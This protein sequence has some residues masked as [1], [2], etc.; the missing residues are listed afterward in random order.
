MSNAANSYDEVPF[1]SQPL[2]HTQPARLG[3]LAALFGMRPAPAGECRLLELG[4]A[5]GG[6]LIPL[7]DR[8]PRA[9]FV[10]IDYSQVQIDAARRA[11]DA[12]GLENLEFNC[13][14]ITD[15]DES[16]GRFDYLVCHG[17]YSWVPRDVQD[18]ILRLCRTAMAPQ[19][20]AYVSYNTYPAWHLRSLA[21]RVLRDVA[22]GDSGYRRVAGGRACLGWLAGAI[23][24]QQTPY[25]QMLAREL[26][27]ILEQPDEYLFHE[28][29]EGHHAPLYFHQFADRA[30]TAGLRYLGDAELH[31]MFA[32]N[33]GRETAARLA[34]LTTDPLA[35][36]QH[37]DLLCNRGFRRS[38]LCHGEVDSSRALLSDRLD[39]LYFSAELTP[40]SPAVDVRSWSSAEFGVAD[41]SK[42]V[43]SAPPV[44][45]LLYCFAT[46][47]PRNLS[48]DELT[49]EVARM[50]GEGPDATRQTVRLNVQQCLS[51]GIVEPT[52]AADDF[53]VNVGRTPTVSRVA[54]FQARTSSDVTN[55]RH[56]I[57]RLDEESRRRLVYLDGQHDPTVDATASGD[58]QTGSGTATPEQIDNWLAALAHRALL[59]R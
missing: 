50:L 17:V 5:T 32:A 30:A 38:L 37:L 15:L 20:V 26:G 55:L 25:A 13:A 23:A 18:A 22:A 35:V 12:L 59:V 24:R 36:E 41:G 2:R 10:G 33:Y 52:S 49:R 7:A 58:N 31:T 9:H 45:A 29:F 6:N 40:R 16:T 34:R 1:P 47:W 48:I 54:R 53:S 21:R 39:E 14:S 42:L 8:Y 11:A 46:H 56:E 27:T 57:V 43:Y 3:A 44:K 51:M 4:C 28:Y 19:G